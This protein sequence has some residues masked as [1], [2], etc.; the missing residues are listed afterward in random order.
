[1]YDLNHVMLSSATSATNEQSGSVSLW[2]Y[3]DLLIIVARS[4][5]RGIVVVTE[6]CGSLGRNGNR[7]QLLKIGYE[8]RHATTGSDRNNHVLAVQLITTFHK[9][10]A[11]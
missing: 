9:C 10:A 5:I 3:R 4:P 7:F 2:N 11:L 6:G 1:M 8:L